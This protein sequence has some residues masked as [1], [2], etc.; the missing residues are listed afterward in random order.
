MS[1]E[2]PSRI[3]LLR[4]AK[5]AYAEGRNVQQTV[6]ALQ[7]S[8]E[9]TPEA[10]EISYDLQAGS[11]AALARTHRE[12]L[13]RYTSEIA[14]HLRRWMA[15]ADSLLDAGT[16]EATTL[17]RV[18]AGLAP[19]RPSRVLAFDLS[20]SRLGAAVEIVL[21]D[22]PASVEE[23]LRLFVGDMSAIP[24]PSRSVDIVMTNHSLEPN[25]GREAELLAE[26]LRVARKHVILFEPAY[27]QA[28]EVSRTRM[29]S[30]GYVR[31]LGSVAESLGA[32]VVAADLLKHPLNPQNPTQCLVIRPR[33][34]AGPSQEPFFSV[35]GTDYLLTERGNN[36]LHSADVGLGWPV[37]LGIPVLKMDAAVLMTGLGQHEDPAPPQE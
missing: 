37:M 1:V 5:A 26:L 12:P 9:N 20:W 29:E 32:T 24:L 6:R 13:E 8:T 17:V 16:G 14:E 34:D 10:V 27:E 31:G 36:V 33:D 2:K 3:E 19:R 18:L 11:Y 4:A 25:H 22:E 28:D 23:D 15:E 30:F 35:P 21:P 7:G